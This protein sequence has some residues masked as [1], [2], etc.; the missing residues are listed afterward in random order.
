MLIR[1]M[2][3]A[4]ISYLDEIHDV[5]Q[6]IG[7]RAIAQKD[8]KVEFVKEASGTYDWMIRTARHITAG[9]L[10][11]KMPKKLAQPNAG[12]AEAGPAEAGPAE[13]GP[14]KA[15]GADAVLADKKD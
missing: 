3:T 11:K 5:R 14:A 2:D 13:A 12:L 4:W 15:E 8:P 1:A 6:G 7:W 10:L 9:E